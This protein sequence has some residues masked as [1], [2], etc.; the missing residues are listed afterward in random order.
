VLPPTITWTDGRIEL[1]DQTA[2]VGPRA[3]IAERLHAYAEAGV[4]TLSVAPHGDSDEQRCK[5][6]SVVA[7]AMDGAGLA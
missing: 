4:T 2:L 1:V 5:V 6:L 7:E 3:R